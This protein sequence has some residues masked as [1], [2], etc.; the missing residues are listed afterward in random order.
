MI[1]GKVSY[2]EL[3]DGDKIIL[4]KKAYNWSPEWQI[5]SRISMLIE[6]GGRQIPKTFVVAAIAE[7]PVYLNF[8]APFM[9][10]SEVLE[11]LCVNNQTY[12]WSIQTEPG[13][14]KAAEA[15]LRQSGSGKPVPEAENF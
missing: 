3:L 5:G 4:N 12:H 10:P 2:E 14:L 13:Q 1:Q 7:P 6:D 11:K 15:Q 9:V 8:Y